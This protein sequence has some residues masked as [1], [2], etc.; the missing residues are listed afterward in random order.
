VEK[1]GELLNLDSSLGVDFAKLL[2]DFDVVEL[3][4]SSGGEERL[5]RFGDRARRRL[6]R[7]GHDERVLATLALA[8]PVTTARGRCSP[9]CTPRISS[10]ARAS[11]PTR[12][13]SA[14]A[15]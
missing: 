9:S 10:R 8:R 5:R 13:P 1:G 6:G 14:I 7:P 3:V 11:R 15:S 12:S 4:F 2:R